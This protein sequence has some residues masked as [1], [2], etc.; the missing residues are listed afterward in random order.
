VRGERERLVGTLVRGSETDGGG[1]KLGRAALVLA[2]RAPA[3]LV[4]AGLG[5]A[6]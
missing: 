3:A 5:R 2:V 1:V 6:V 4:P